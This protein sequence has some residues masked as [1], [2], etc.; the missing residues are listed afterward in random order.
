MAKTKGQKQK[1]KPKQQK[2]EQQVVQYDEDKPFDFGGLPQ[3]DIK[4]NLGCG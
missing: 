3:R 2:G 4:K 1:E